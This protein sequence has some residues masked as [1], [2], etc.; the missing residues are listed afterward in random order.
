M[1]WAAR[2]ELL[3]SGFCFI[4]EFA[5]PGNNRK[6]IS[7]QINIG[8]ILND[9]ERAIIFKYFIADACRTEIK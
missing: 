9:A 6:I 5:Q 1:N 4:G 2:I 8:I 3:G 7:W